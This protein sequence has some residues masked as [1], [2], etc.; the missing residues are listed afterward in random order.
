LQVQKASQLVEQGHIRVG[1]E[2]VTDPAFL[3]TRVHSD[4]IAWARESKM[5][6]HVQAYNN[7]RDDFEDDGC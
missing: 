4:Q 7:R 6:R 1:I 5:R 3:V 2:L